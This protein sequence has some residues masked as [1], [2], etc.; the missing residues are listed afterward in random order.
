VGKKKKIDTR[1]QLQ[2]LRQTYITQIIAP[3]FKQKQGNEK[4]TRKKMK[5]ENGKLTWTFQSS[6]T[7]SRMYDAMR[8][9]WCVC[10]T[11][12]IGV[13]SGTHSIAPR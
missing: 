5:K 6:L 7:P 10:R 12:S 4:A 2:I 9:G 8:F 13:V 1:P 11:H 3:P